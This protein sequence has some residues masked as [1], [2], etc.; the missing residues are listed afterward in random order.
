MISSHFLSLPEYVELPLSHRLI[1][2]QS[3]IRENLQD[4]FRTSIRLHRWNRFNS[5]ESSRPPLPTWRRQQSISF[6]RNQI[7]RGQL[8]REFFPRWQPFPALWTTYP[9]RLRQGCI[10]RFEDLRVVSSLHGV[11]VGARTP[12]GVYG[13]W[14]SF[15]GCVVL[16]RA[17]EKILWRERS[18]RLQY[19]QYSS[20]NKGLA[21]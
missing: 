10:R 4:T 3:L 1:T 21:G 19:S 5:G 18:E 12:P 15:H 17:A 9:P 11:H 6:D 2:F 13:G 7:R 8:F 14:Q 20:E 16:H